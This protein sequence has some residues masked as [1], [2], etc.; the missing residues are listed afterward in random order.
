MEKDRDRESSESGIKLN[1]EKCESWKKRGML[2]EDDR[3]DVI[4]HEQEEE[5]EAE[6]ERETEGG[7]GQRENNVDS[8]N[9]TRVHIDQI[10]EERGHTTDTYWANDEYV[11][12]SV[13]HCVR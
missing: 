6:S 5:K 13:Y 8:A 7:E 1:S 9:G 11:S 12:D 3:Q 2:K 4:W 10:P